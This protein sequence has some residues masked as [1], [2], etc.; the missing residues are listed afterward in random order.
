KWKFEHKK[1]KENTYD[2]I[3]TANIT[4]PNFH[5]WAL[6]TTGD[7]T[8]I[9]TTLIIPKGSHYKMVGSVKANGK[10]AT[11]DDELMGPLQ[12][13]SGI[14]KYTQRIEV[15]QNTTIKGHAYF[16][17]CNEEGQCLRPTE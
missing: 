2:I 17:T 5:V 3:G 10:I 12:Y 11:T 16:Q 4:M 13:Y 1:V 15:T 14:V 6:G 7:G 8:L 9:P